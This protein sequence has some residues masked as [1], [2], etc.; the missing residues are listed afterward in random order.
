MVSVTRYLIHLSFNWYFPHLLL[1]LLANWKSFVEELV[2]VF[3]D[4]YIGSPFSCWIQILSITCM[5]CKC[6]VCLVAYN[7]TLLMV[8]FDEQE[9]NL[10]Y[11]I[12]QLSPLWLMFFV[13]F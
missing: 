6:I 1:C 2:Q 10:T 7:L 12:Y 3:C 8:C 11:L 13:N 4:H 9:C 5:S